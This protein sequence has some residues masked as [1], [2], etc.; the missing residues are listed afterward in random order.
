MQQRPTVGCQHPHA[1]QLAAVSHCSC[2][3]RQAACRGM[4]IP[5]RRFPTSPT[6]AVKKARDEIRRIGPGIHVGEGLRVAAFLVIK[7]AFLEWLEH[8][9]VDKDAELDLWAEA[10][11]QEAVGEG[12]IFGEGRQVPHPPH[13]FLRHAQIDV[14]VQRTA[15]LSSQPRTWHKNSHKES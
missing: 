1:V 8:L 4:H 10:G 5:M 11:G 6:V 2:K 15:N 7:K 14:S 9:G 13:L 3:P 12:A